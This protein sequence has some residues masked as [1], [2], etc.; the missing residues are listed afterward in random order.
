MDFNLDCNLKM[1]KKLNTEQKELINKIKKVYA[2]FINSRN[3]LFYLF[4]SASKIKIPITQLAK[5]LTIDKSAV[6]RRMKRSN[7]KKLNN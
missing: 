6:W 3:E 5:E 2:K 7:N 1:I 4:N